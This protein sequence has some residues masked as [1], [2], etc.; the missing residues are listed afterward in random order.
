MFI[1]TMDVGE[2]VNIDR[3]V[4]FRIMDT[5]ATSHV[6]AWTGMLERDGDELRYFLF[7]GTREACVGYMA[8][9]SENL[10]NRDLLL[11]V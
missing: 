2:L 5:N 1:K 6:V 10:R 11:H 7:R 8:R 3:I 4:F 9:L